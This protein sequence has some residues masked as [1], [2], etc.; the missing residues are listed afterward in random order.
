MLGD[1]PAARQALETFTARVG[2]SHNAY[3][4]TA[5]PYLGDVC[6]RMGDLPEARQAYEKAL[7]AYPEG[8]LADRARFGLGRTLALQNEPDDGAE[9]PRPRWPSKAARDWADRAWF[10][11]GMSRR[12]P[13]R[14]DKA[15]EAFET[16]ET[17]SRRRA[18]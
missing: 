8:R 9:G 12:E 11:I 15:V 5:W 3:L 2:P 7:A 6:L 14:Y 4:E 10:Q 18:R 17:Q 1:L 16:L 13:A